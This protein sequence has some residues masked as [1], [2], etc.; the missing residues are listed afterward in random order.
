MEPFLAS[1]LVE[2]VAS[3]GERPA[4]MERQRGQ[5]L[6]Q[7]APY[8]TLN[9]VVDHWKHLVDQLRHNL[10]HQS[11]EARPLVE[12]HSSAENNSSGSDT[13]HQCYKRFLA[14]CL[15]SSSALALMA[16]KDSWVGFVAAQAI[17]KLG[18]QPLRQLLAEVVWGTRPL[19][20]KLLAAMAEEIAL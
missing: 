2:L 11:S 4:Q 14:Q 6:A 18:G 10:Q 15:L 7:Q 3:M 1:L 5:L 16:E 12:N 8:C 13:R 20:E 17:V 19:A 9:I